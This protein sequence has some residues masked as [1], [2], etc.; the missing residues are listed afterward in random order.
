M[1]NYKVNKKEEADEAITLVLKHL[2]VDTKKRGLRLRFAG[3]LTCVSGIGA[4]AAQCVSLARAINNL[5]S[6]RSM[7]SYSL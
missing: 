1:P 2:G 5:V 4:S 6:C 7:T 3:D